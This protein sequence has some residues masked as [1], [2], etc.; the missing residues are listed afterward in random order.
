MWTNWQELKKRKRVN[1][2]LRLAYQPY[3]W[4]IVIPFLFLITMGLGLI[5]IIVGF[6]FSQDAADILAVFWSRLCCAIVPVKVR[7]KGK[8]NHS[9][10]PL[11]FTA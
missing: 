10:H 11:H 9:R 4:L 2:F 1:E 3:K 6:I 7:I 8:S 5:C